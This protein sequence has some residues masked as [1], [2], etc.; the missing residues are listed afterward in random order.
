M[1][2]R[3]RVWIGKHKSQL[4]RIYNKKVLQESSENIKLDEGMDEF[5]KLKHKLPKS[6][7][8][9]PENNPKKRLKLLTYGT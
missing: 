7:K 8:L 1:C 3:D 4:E 6:V 9:S 2:I 5:I